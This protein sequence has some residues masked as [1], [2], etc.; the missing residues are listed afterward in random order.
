MDILLRE[1][2]KI[3][4]NPNYLLN[5]SDI[6]IICSNEEGLSNSILE[7]MNFNLPIVATKV[8]G[9]PEMIKNNFLRFNFILGS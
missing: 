3:Y 5:R 4:L 1:L 9:N 6:G 2:V 7:Y 8:G